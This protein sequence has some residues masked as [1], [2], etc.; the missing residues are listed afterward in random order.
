MAYRAWGFLLQR[1]PSGVVAPFALLAPCTGVISAASVFGELPGAAR[2]AGMVL[3]LAGLA[4]I[5]LLEGAAA[6]GA[7]DVH[8]VTGWGVAPLTARPR[9]RE[10]AGPGA[11]RR[12]PR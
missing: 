10:R 8:A 1:Y 6:S 7:A 5:V 3:I 9:E 11:G 4:V 2:W 12:E